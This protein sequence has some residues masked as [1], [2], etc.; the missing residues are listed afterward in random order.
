MRGWSRFSRR[1]NS[2]GLTENY[3]ISHIHTYFSTCSRRAVTHLSLDK[4]KRKLYCKKVNFIDVRI[5]IQLYKVH[6][7]SFPTLRN[8]VVV[9]PIKSLQTRYLYKWDDLELTKRDSHKSFFSWCHCQIDNKTRRR[10]Y[11]VMGIIKKPVK[12]NGERQPKYRARFSSNVFKISGDTLDTCFTSSLISLCNFSANRRRG[13]MEIKKLRAHTTQRHET[14]E[15]IETKNVLHNSRPFPSF[16]TSHHSRSKKHSC[17][18]FFL[19]VS[20]CVLNC[21][22]VCPYNHYA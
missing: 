10:S 16:S 15:E 14:F 19:S 20:M 9:H 2:E 13:T 1:I 17:F 11:Y 21:T 12:H 18:F 5:Q 22:W 3:S 4:Y 7:L 6:L 8:V